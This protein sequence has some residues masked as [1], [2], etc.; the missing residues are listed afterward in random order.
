MRDQIKICLYG[1]SVSEQSGMSGYSNYLKSDIVQRIDADID[2]SKVTF[3]SASFNDAG[4]CHIDHIVAHKPNFVIF[5]WLSTSEC[6]FDLGKLKFFMT[7]LL[8]NSI[9]P[10]VVDFPRADSI[11]SR[12]VNHFQ[13]LE[14]SKLM[15]ISYLD[16]TSYCLSNGL[17]I[18]D[19]TRDGVHSNEEGA[20]LYS[21]LL[22]EYVADLVLQGDYL[23]RCFYDR[24][25]ESS[26][27]I[28]N[29]SISAPVVLGAN[30][31]LNFRVFPTHFSGDSISEV[32][33]MQIVG[34][35]SPIV[36]LTCMELNF[37]EEIQI[38]DE[39]CHYDRLAF[40]N[41]IPKF[42]FKE[43]GYSDVNFS[44]RL[45]NKR[46]DYSN[47]RREGV[48]FPDDLYIKLVDNIFS[49]NCVLIL[50]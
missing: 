22:S 45:L 11:V 13:S 49:I 7:R 26:Y 23:Q 50:K 27:L 9:Y 12:R 20:R 16:V 3:P 37:R 25:F 31:V 42:S 2:I 14:I 43:V 17:S 10:I 30:D 29:S 32:W 38:W 36:E 34:A 8:R 33:G 15:K 1:A 21:R 40:K 48:S 41:I 4:F 19:V 6:E 28:C 39:W 46:P 18:N 44:M 5:E 47:C 35:F 24:A